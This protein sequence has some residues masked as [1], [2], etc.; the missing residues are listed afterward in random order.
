MVVFLHAEPAI[1]GWS[2]TQMSSEHIPS[3]IVGTI[4]LCLTRF[5]QSIPGLDAASWFYLGL[6]VFM[7]LNGLS[8]AGTFFRYR[9]VAGFVALIL[10]IILVPLDGG[11]TQIGTY[12]SRFGFFRVFLQPLIWLIVMYREDGAANCVR[13]MRTLRFFST[14]FTCFISVSYGR[15]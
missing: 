5:Q 14:S 12:V 8:L 11:R 2:I 7:A 3:N 10:L 9:Y 1:D 4:M 6:G 13:H 15:F